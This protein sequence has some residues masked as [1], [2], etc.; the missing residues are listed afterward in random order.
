MNKVM[1]VGRRYT[2][3]QLKRSK[4]L[5]DDGAKNKTTWKTLSAACSWS[6]SSTLSSPFCRQSK[7]RGRENMQR[8]DILTFV[9]N[10]ALEQNRFPVHCFYF[11]ESFITFR[12]TDLKRGNLSVSFQ[13]S[14][15]SGTH[16]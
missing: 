11:S 4:C 9:S 8:L 13:Y 5:L 12:L 10:L 6:F 14:V 2:E 16:L 3:K 7:S 15:D 1:F